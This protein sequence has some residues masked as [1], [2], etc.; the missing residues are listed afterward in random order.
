LVLVCRLGWL[1]GL[2]RLLLEGHVKG[3][4]NLLL[5]LLLL[6]GELLLPLVIL[7]A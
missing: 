7:L 2:L 6:L 4:L 1:L 5:L 3:G